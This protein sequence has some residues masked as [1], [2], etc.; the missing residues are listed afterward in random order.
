[1]ESFQEWLSSLKSNLEGAQTW[2]GFDYRE[3]I[4]DAFVNIFVKGTESIF[5]YFGEFILAFTRLPLLIVEMDYPKQIFGYAMAVSLMLVVAKAMNL[6]RIP[7]VLIDYEE[8]EVWSLRETEEV[9]RAE[10]VRRALA[11]DLYPYKTAKHKFPITHL[12]CNFTLK[13]LMK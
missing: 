7:V 12:A 2:G 8:I 6:R 9:S 10:V 11:G 1:M 13:E 4:W 3:S 5:D